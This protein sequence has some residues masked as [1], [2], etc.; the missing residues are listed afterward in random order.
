MFPYPVGRTSSRSK[1]MDIDPRSTEESRSIRGSHQGVSH[2]VDNRRNWLKMKMTE[3]SYVV[4]I[5]DGQCRNVSTSKQFRRIVAFIHSGN[6][7]GICVSR[8]KRSCGSYL[9]KHLPVWFWFGYLGSYGQIK[10][11]PQVGGFGGPGQMQPSSL[12]TEP[13]GISLFSSAIAR[14]GRSRR[15]S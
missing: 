2:S 4:R 15:V 1:P 11:F 12:K 7:G 14:P 10:R 13:S 8:W 3:T 9:M 5:N 6:F